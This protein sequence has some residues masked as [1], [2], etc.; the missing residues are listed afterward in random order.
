MWTSKTKW[1]GHVESERSSAT[2]LAT[3]GTPDST[4]TSGKIALVDASVRQIATAA[5]LKAWQRHKKRAE[6]LLPV[7]NLVAHHP[8]LET[9]SSGPK[10]ASYQY[11]IRLEPNEVGIGKRPRSVD[12]EK[13]RRHATQ[14][15]KLTHRLIALVPKIVAD[16]KA[17][18]KERPDGAL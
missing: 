13:L 11:S 7:R 1:P 15:D 9:V 8:L 2:V 16:S 3:T 14:V 4:S 10:R 5:N 18:S 17:R 6:Q 12:A